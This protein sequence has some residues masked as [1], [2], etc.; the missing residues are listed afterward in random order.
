M[1]ASDIDFFRYFP[2]AD[3]DRQWGMYVSGVGASHIPTDYT[4][5]PLRSHPDSYMFRWDRGRRLVEFGAILVSAGEG[6]FESEATGN[7]HVTAG[8]VLLLFPGVWHRYRP[9][10]ESGW[11]EY[12]VHFGGEH[13]DRLVERK[14]FSPETPVLKTGLDSSILHAHWEMIDRAH[15]NPVGLPQLNAASVH[16]ILAAAWAAPRR[17]MVSNR[18]LELVR[19]AKAA[20]EAGVEGNVAIA[21]VASSLG[22]SEAHI[23]RLFYAQVG[24]PPYQYYLELKVHRAQQML[25]ETSWPIKRI[26]KTLGFENPFHFAKVFKQRTGL[27][28]SQWRRAGRG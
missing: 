4:S 3:R 28:P 20:L 25:R 19:D 16:D 8:S 18:A 21:A 15:T 13:I 24:M 10:Q 26:S 5:Y 23:R 2:V 22:V 7:I 9:F 14:F 12:W 1:R 11:D 6:E 17:E 27:T